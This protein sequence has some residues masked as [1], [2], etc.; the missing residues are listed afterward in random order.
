MRFKKFLQI[1][2][3]CLILGVSQSGVCAEVEIV[4]AALVMSLPSSWGEKS[5]Q[6][7]IPTGQILQRW[8]RHP[9]KV[10]QY[11]A[12]PGML[13]IATPVPKDADLAL[14]TQ[15][16]LRREPYSV[17]L[18][19]ETQCIK[20]F[21]FQMA[22]NEG[23][24]SGITPYPP[25]SCKEDGQGVESDCLYRKVD[26]LGLNLEPSWANRFEKDGLPYGKSY[27]MIVHM[28]VGGKFVE[29]SFVY[30]KQVAQQIEP[31]ISAI[32]SS[33]RAINTV[34]K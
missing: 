31:E 23:V 21:M 19:G 1:G 32:V 16:V 2:M 15:G 27:Y 18:G 25:Q 33:I 11:N 8:V 29:I 7:K 4:E 6:A 5:E 22:K 10:G 13:A 30:P 34:S 3:A 17:K 24:I 12:M 14:L 28:L 26:Y 9:I 20:C